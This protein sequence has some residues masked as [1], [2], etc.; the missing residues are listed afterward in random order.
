[1]RL[2]SKFSFKNS[3]KKDGCIILIHCGVNW[4]RRGLET[5]YFCNV[6]LLGVSCKVCKADP[7]LEKEET[8]N[9]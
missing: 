8:K 9:A 6:F 3:K 5:C 4:S 2:N 1:M 7:F